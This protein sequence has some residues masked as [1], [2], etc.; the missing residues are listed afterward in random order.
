[1]EEKTLYNIS[2]S[3]ANILFLIF[4]RFLKSVEMETMHWNQKVP[5]ELLLNFILFVLIFYR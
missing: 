2:Y 3:D 4:F 5:T 1:M